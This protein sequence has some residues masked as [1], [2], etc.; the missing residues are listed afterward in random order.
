M[1]VAAAPAMVPPV[2]STTM[3]GSAGLGGLR[4][5]LG[6]HGGGLGR[7][8]HGRSRHGHAGDERGRMTVVS[9]YEVSYLVK[10]TMTG[11]HAVSR[12]LPMAYGTV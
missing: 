1:S 2:A 3:V 9:A 11:P 7:G 6:G 8:Q 12:M 10:M 4:G 5:G